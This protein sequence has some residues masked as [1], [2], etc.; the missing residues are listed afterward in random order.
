M[1]NAD[2]SYL[3]ARLPIG[4]SFFGHGLARLPKLNAFSHWMTESFSASI[5]PASL[6]RPFSYLLPILELLIGI[7]LLLGLYSRHA[8]ILG[9]LL[10][11]VLIFGSS[12]LEQWSN[13]FL[14]MIYGAYFSLLYKYVYYNRLSFDYLIFKQTRPLEFIP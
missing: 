1:K 3:L 10:I 14:Q 9:A 12:L 11:L 6:V 5:L 2:V 7:L 13:V 8:I 4:M